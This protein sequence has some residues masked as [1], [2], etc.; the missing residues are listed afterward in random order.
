MCVNVHELR[1]HFQH[2]EDSLALQI[3]PTIQHQ[4]RAIFS[5]LQRYN[6][7]QFS[8]VTTQVAGYQQFLASLQ[9][10]ARHSQKNARI[11]VSG[12]NRKR[13]GPAKTHPFLFVC[14]FSFLFHTDRR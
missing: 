13:W 7:T 9:T 1:M 5:L 11:T 14:F 6:W 10:I 4:A 12:T 8:V 2:P 3:A